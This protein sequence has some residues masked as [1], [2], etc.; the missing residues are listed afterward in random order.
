MI[1]AFNDVATVTVENIATLTHRY[2]FNS[3]TSDSVGTANGTLQ[4]GANVSGGSLVLDGNPGSY[5]ELPPGLLQ[6]YPAVTVDT[7]VTF[8]TAQTWARLWYFGDDRADEFYI[9]PSVPDGL[10]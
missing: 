4:G 7:W 1:T 10:F 8:N 6:G 3:D 5:V 2:T 9:A